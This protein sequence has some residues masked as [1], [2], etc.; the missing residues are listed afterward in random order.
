LNFK[1]GFEDLEKV[2]N[3][4]KM[5]VRCRKSIEILKKKSEVSEH[6]CAEGKAIHCQLCSIEQCAK[7]TF[8]NPLPPSRATIVALGFLVITRQ[9]Q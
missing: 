3:L 6:N 8:R 2:L 1:I 9:P 5:Y 7:L 4:A